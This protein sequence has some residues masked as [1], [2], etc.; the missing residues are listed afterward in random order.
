[1]NRLTILS[2][3]LLSVVVWSSCETFHIVPVD[4]TEMCE[5]K[6]CLT[7]DQLANETLD[8]HYGNLTLYFTP[9]S[10]FLRQNLR[11]DGSNVKMIGL[12][13]NS[14]IW[15]QEL[16]SLRIFNVKVLVMDNVKFASGSNHTLQEF[17]Q[18]HFETSRNLLIKDCV[19]KGVELKAV[20]D[21]TTIVAC[22]FVKT[23]IEV[24]TSFLSIS[25]CSFNQSQC[26][27][28]LDKIYQVHNHFLSG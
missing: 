18:C 19:F 26:N 17:V 4:S 8:Q 15:I 22:T 6:P 5:K 21:K 7:L 12:S 25:L 20:S 3:L 28:K 2:V 14:T 1:M 13:L 9:G 24:L 27:A 10:H 23:N 16:M 11:L